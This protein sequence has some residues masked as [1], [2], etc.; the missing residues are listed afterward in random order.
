MTA[1]T[2]VVSLSEAARRR[3]ARDKARRRDTARGKTL[4]ARG[5]HKWQVDQRKQFDVRSGRLI[6]VRRCERC[7]AERTTLD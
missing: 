3:A 1:M 6:T 7:G 4:C 5:F 2:K